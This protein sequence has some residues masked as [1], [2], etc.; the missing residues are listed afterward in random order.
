MD[1]V[2]FD[3]P[4]LQYYLH[5][6][7]KER[8]KLSQVSFASEAY[9]FIVSPDRSFLKNLDIRLL[10]MKENGKI[11]EIESKWL[12]YSKRKGIGNRE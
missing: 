1:G 3:V 4:A 5:N 2:V 8:L 6:N 10:E 12:S 9:G 7:P 11:K